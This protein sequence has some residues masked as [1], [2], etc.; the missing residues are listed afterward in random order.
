MEYTLK[1]NTK[2]EIGQYV[3]I[4]MPAQKH[5]SY[6]DCHSCGHKNEK[7]TG[8][9]SPPCVQKYKITEIQIDT[10]TAIYVTR[11]IQFY[12]A[13]VP[14]NDYPKQYSYYGINQQAR[15]V[16]EVYL[17]ATEEE[18]NLN[19]ADEEKWSNNL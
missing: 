4:I 7:S 6:S 12:Y 15:L 16:S 5:Y 2:F 3:W 18:A 8:Y 19:L 1:I 9:V 17:F 14:E 10:K 11:G 13:V